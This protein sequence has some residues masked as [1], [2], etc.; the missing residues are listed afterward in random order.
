[1]DRSVIRSQIVG[2]VVDEQAT[3]DARQEA[4]FF[5][6]IGEKLFYLIFFDT[7]FFFFCFHVRF[8]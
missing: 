3:L 8:S 7:F 5:F 6:C 1:M 4:V 2:I